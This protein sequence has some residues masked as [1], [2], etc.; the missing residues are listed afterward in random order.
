MDILNK[1][2]EELQVERWQVEAAVKLI[3]EGNTIPFISRYRK[4]A[5]GSLNDEVLRN[6]YERLNYLRNLEEKKT[7][8]MASIEEQGKLTDDLKNKILA[9]ETLVV[10]EDLYRPYRPKRKTRASVAKEK[11]LDGLADLIREQ[12]FSGSL[13]EAAAAYVNP[14][15]GAADTKEA[16]QGAQDILAEGIS[17]E[18][19]YRMYIRK[20]TMD[21]G[22]LTSTA[23]DEKAQSVYEMYYQYEEPLKKAAGHRV[24]ALNRG[25]AEKFLTVKVEAPRDRILQYLA[26]KVITEENP[27]T[28]AVLR[29]VIEDSYDRLIAP[30][31]ERDIR[32]ELTE[33]AEE[34]AI[35]VFGKNLE[36]LLMQPPI[37]GHV[38]LGW[39][40]AFRTGCKL[41]VVDATGKV[42]DTK[43][44]YPTAPQNKV[45]EA[46]KELKKLIDKYDISLISVGNGTA[47]RESEQVIVDLIKEL[48]KPVQYVIVNEAGA[49]VYSASK[50]ATEEFP[51]FDVGQRSAASIARRLQDPLS[52]LVKIDPKS[53]GVGQYQH[54]M[55]QK[56]LGEALGGVVEDCV[57]RVGVDLNTA[58]AP[59]LEYISGISKTVAKNIVEYREANGRFTN[60]KQLLKVPKL[61]PKAFEQC[62]GFLRI[63]DGEN[64]LDATSVHPESYPA[65]M[66]LLKKLELSM[67]DV[68]MLQ[69]EAKKGRAAQN[70][71]GAD[72]KNT[73]GD[74]A[75]QNVSA[76]GKANR[77]DRRQNGFNIRN[78]DTAMG[79]ALAAAMQGMTLDADN[80]GTGKK[81]ANASG[82]S[83]AGASNAANT[84][85]GATA[86]SS[87]SGSQKTAAVSALER[88]I[89]DKKKLAD[90]LGIGEITLTDIVREL[91]KPARD[92]RED[93][94]RPI[95]RSDVLDMKDL[96][97]GMVLKG[98]VRNVIDF[99]VFVD[100]GVHQDGL[101]H[102]SQITDR[103]IK[104]PLEAVSV[105]DIVDVKVLDVDPVK[106]R[107][108]LTMRLDQK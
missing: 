28:E 93:M 90:E 31:I 86:G 40:P 13:E 61:G 88:R 84:S 54:D 68:R 9:A 21:E 53:I 16:L 44:I 76:K 65:T 48:K 66:E 4:E 75:R 51:Q 70:T 37:A 35:S 27:V 77:K 26:K 94:P 98:T 91:E 11:G 85:T 33:K 32:N 101:V 107:I 100:I 87:T 79:R 67:E 14:E 49:S 6:L 38:V 74:A 18:A 52:E 83:G 81:G 99:G 63:A 71:S 41:A 55:N 108:G 23:R 72:S 10:V 25:E 50:L 42:L 62:A 2:R 102:I 69:A 3:D 36:Q 20:I 39:D 15:K 24:L 46:K 43:V 45:E 105:G 60:R 57:N 89:P 92:P 7:S 80:S 5:T 73:S 17:D 103:F 1:L 8:V 96:K 82:R 97:P 56:K 106:K 78:T 64:P 19:D 104:H 12:K 59:L 95:L 30:A 29:A 34:G 22:K 58:S 47:S